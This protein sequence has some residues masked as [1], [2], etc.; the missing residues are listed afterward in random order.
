ML[1]GVPTPAV[2]YASRLRAELR[3]SLHVSYS[4]SSFSRVPHLLPTPSFIWPA[5]R[6][7][8][9]GSEVSRV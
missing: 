2:R 9:V 5:S 4:S 6:S 1:Y 8:T 3:H 7:Y